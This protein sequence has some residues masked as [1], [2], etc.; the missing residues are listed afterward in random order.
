M[1]TIVPHRE[2]IDAATAD[3]P[4]V[5]DAHLGTSHDLPLDRVDR[6]SGERLERPAVVPVIPVPVIPGKRP[7]QLLLAGEHVIDFGRVCVA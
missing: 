1:K 4:G 3:G 7:P 6:L 2:F 5:R